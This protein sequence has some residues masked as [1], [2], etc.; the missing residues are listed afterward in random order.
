MRDV[1]VAGGG[2]AGLVTALYAR[3]A[4]LTVTLLEPRPTPIDKACG[5]GL[6]PGAVAALADLGVHVGGRPFRG[7]RYCAGPHRA[8]ADFREGLGRGVRRT[9]LQARLWQAAEA[10][11]VELR[12]GRVDGLEQRVGHVTAAGQSARYLVA[13][14]GL[15]S[16]VRHVAGLAGGPARHRRWG[17]RAHFACAPWSDRVE[18]HWSADAEAYVTPVGPDCVGVALLTDRPAPFADLLAAFPELVARLPATPVAPVRGAGPLHQRVTRAVAGRVLLVGDAAGY[19]DALTGEGLAIS[20]ASARA[21]I[22]R[23]AADDPDGYAGDL[24]AITRRYRWLTG[25]LLAAGRVP[26]LRRNLVPVAERAP[27]LFRAAVGQL[28]R[29]AP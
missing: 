5:E 25:V 12:Q 4:G 14:D 18:V 23:I 15:H 27:W 29:D 3:R 13:A 1:L 8:V 24:R 20:F 26:M 17:Q 21:L 19:V 22:T 11:G 16:P 7:I 2:P 6:M 28:A 10:A 9:E